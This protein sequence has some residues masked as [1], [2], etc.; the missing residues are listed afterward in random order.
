[1]ETIV[2]RSVVQVS[3]PYPGLRPF[4]HDEAE[5]FFGRE[6]QTDQLLE[7][8][9]R[10]RFIA[11][12]G[13]SGCGKSSLVRAGLVAALEAGFLAD[14]GARWRFAE[15][16]PGDRPFERLAE[17]LLTP[18]ALG[19]GG[20]ADASET[21]L[22]RAMLRRGPLGLV[23]IVQ[24]A[25]TPESENLLIVV[26]QFEEIFR[27]RDN[28]YE[29]DAD[30]FVA[31]LLES[32][33][34]RD[35]PIY[36]IITMRSDFLGECALFLGLPEV[37]NESQYLTPR[38]T[39]EQIRAA[40]AG[41]ARVLSG[42]IDPV[43]VNHLVNEVGPDPDQLPL[44]Q[45]VLMR[46]WAQ[47]TD[48]ELQQKKSATSRV[49]RLVTMHDYEAVG[50][51]SNALSSHADQVVDSMTPRQQEIARVMMSR[52]TERGIG[53]RDIRHP[54]RVCN[55]AKVAG[56]TLQEVITVAE[57]LRQPDR[58]FL[59]P[60]PPAPLE[61]D[62]VLDIGH[63]S[64]IRR[65]GKLYQWA[66]EEAASAA[67]YRRILIT[68]AAWKK[69]QSA[70]WGSPDLDE[71]LKW[72]NDR[73]PDEAWAS[74]YGSGED[75][76]TAMEFI[77]ASEQHAIRLREKQFEEEERERRAET[78]RRL[79]KWIKFGSLLALVVAIG[80]TSLAF[81][82]R[83]QQAEAE[84]QSAKAEHSRRVADLAKAESER[85]KLVAQRN[86]RTATDA[87]HVAEQE[88]RKAQ[89]AR[90]AAQ[91]AASE[92]HYQARL[93][94]SAKGEADTQRA[95]AESLGKEARSREVATNAIVAAQGVDPEL[96]LLLAMEA[97]RISPTHQADGALEEA[98]HR[99]KL[100]LQTAPKSVHSIT[101]LP[102]GKL[103]LYERSAPTGTNG[104]ND[105]IVEIRSIDPAVK[106]TIFDTHRTDERDPFS[107]PDATLFVF[108]DDVGTLRIV[109]TSGKVVQTLDASAAYASFSP[110]GK[111]LMAVAKNGDLRVWQTALWNPL[112]I[113]ETIDQN[114][115]G[116][117]YAPDSSKLAAEDRDAR[118]HVWDTLTGEEIVSFK[119][120]GGK[121]SVA[122]F[123]PDGRYIVTTHG[124]DMAALRYLP[125]ETPL[126][127][128]GDH[129]HPV[130]EVEFSPDSKQIVGIGAAGVAKILYCSLGKKQPDKA[131][132]LNSAQVLLVDDPKH[133]I[134]LNLPAD[135]TPLCS[136]IFSPDSREILTIEAGVARIWKNPL[137]HPSEDAI[138]ESRKLTGDEV[139]VRS[140][141]FSK[142]GRWI[143]T[144]GQ[145]GRARLWNASTFQPVASFASEST[146]WLS[147]ISEDSR[148]FL[149][150]SSD[151][152]VRIWDTF[153][154]GQEI[155]LSGLPEGRDSG[156]A[157]ITLPNTDYE[158]AI[159]PDGKTVLAIG[160]DKTPRIWDI[161]TGRLKV[162]L[163]NGAHKTGRAS[164]SL[165]GKRVI[166]FD[167][168]RKGRVWDSQTGTEIAQVGANES[169][170]TMAD[171]AD[172][173]HVFLWDLPKRT[174]S[175]WN[176]D[177]GQPDANLPVKIKLHET[178]RCATASPDGRWLAICQDSVPEAQ[179][180]RGVSPAVDVFDLLAPDESPRR[181]VGHAGNVV[182][183]FFSRDGKYAISAG[184]DKTAIVWEVGTWREVS[185]L[186]GHDST[187]KAAMMS[188]D[189]K[190]VATIDS[191]NTVRLFAADTG[192]Q[193]SL[194]EMRGH[195]DQISAIAFSP[196]GRWI[197]TGSNDDSVRVWDA[198][199]GR[200]VSEFYGH[201][202]PVIAVAFGKDPHSII[203]V[204]SEG[205]IRNY[206]CG[207]CIAPSDLIVTSRKR[208]TELG[209]TLTD[210][211]RHRYLP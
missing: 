113:H 42:E 174:V 178:A 97:E 154:M 76:R 40:I 24:E 144:I 158:S 72:R 103:V 58:S 9:Q 47:V 114:V 186:K 204:G 43:L 20:E 69:G 172:N 198:M 8:L 142:D 171:F 173:N 94:L 1:M 156:D 54:A 187:V 78:Q 160:A 106:P 108:T 30:A 45:H 104:P 82:A 161:S 183:V 51:L 139:P 179:V 32:A 52:L 203:S 110:D 209:R 70:L 112:E 83:A 169:E 111:T 124:S 109:D 121:N 208:M 28:G 90:D 80:T 48:A 60:P 181:L 150:W 176:L 4:R 6:K 102:N 131:P 98:A 77:E 74:R 129:K 21:A 157:R 75:F 2:C 137:E 146:V 56:A 25:R 210:D 87:K 168:D 101:P 145:D 206:H 143:A 184:F 155:A 151:S 3:V 49:P 31:L 17:A 11:V 65:W 122:R 120:E 46:M 64:L 84:R 211:E 92:A 18:S 163:G 190:R 50:T 189:D 36:V 192:K 86:E 153:D 22:I 26:D 67:M 166:T 12:V 107:N 55:I 132:Q 66:D 125:S 195:T 118:W 180:Q 133:V 34:Q 35:V 71:A 138:K 194:T 123:S 62:T 147:V 159:S 37:I 165:D 130:Q 39:R 197:V 140:A 23:E 148:Q 95:R 182:D 115:P 10:S 19:S 91:A 185:R 126:A 135:E 5:I 53:K 33:A 200:A 162:W 152:V 57:Q 117:A 105:W 16:R 73:E 99:S 201:T 14:A 7:K 199:T 63:E 149:T 85:Q 13:P 100:R 136:A 164:F 128:I 141:W 27:F 127:E 177:S 89:R 188:A 96:G 68:S 79:Y 202:E 193:I 61:P 175:V 119:D 116:P 15:M 59:T 191:S 167:D 134:Q 38:L 207:A 205:T 44:L 93:A 88:R 41:P 170:A 81:W 29:D 196:D